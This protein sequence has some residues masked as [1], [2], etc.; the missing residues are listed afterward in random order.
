M[1]PGF[2][3]TLPLCSERLSCFKQD[4]D[5]FLAS[6]QIY[7]SPVLCEQ[8]ANVRDTCR[9][10]AEKPVILFVVVPRGVGW[11]WD[12]NQAQTEFLADSMEESVVHAQNM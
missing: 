11:G 8:C 9:N 4:V 2:C 6:I 1:Q 7:F 5:F 12:V 3:D 10:R